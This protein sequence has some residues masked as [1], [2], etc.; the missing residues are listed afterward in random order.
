MDFKWI[1]LGIVLFFFI[2]CKTTEVKP[3]MIDKKKSCDA[4]SYELKTVQQKIYLNHSSEKSNTIRDKS[5][6][7]AGTA[8]SVMPQLLLSPYWYVAPSLTIWYYN[9]FIVNNQRFEYK[10]YLKK[11]VLVLQ[12]IIQNRCKE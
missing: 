4:L 6:V 12:K 1:F 3:R 7:V 10:Q 5:F 2:G 11:R 8:I 9:M